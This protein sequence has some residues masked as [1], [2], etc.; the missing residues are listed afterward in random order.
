MPYHLIK[1]L[2]RR[3]WIFFTGFFLALMQMSKVSDSRYRAK[4]YFVKSDK[5]IL[6]EARE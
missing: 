6:K 4:K 5:D 2:I 1:A 3:D